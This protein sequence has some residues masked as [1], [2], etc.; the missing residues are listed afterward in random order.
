MDL[1]TT[2]T[3]I[4]WLN[5]QVTNKFPISPTTFLDAAVKLNLLLAD[6]QAHLF[7]LEQK[8]AQLR[9]DFLNEDDK[10]NVSKAKLL[11]EASEEFKDSKNQ[12]AKI[13]RIIEFIRLAKVQ[14]KLTMEEMRGGGLYA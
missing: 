1:V 13:D 3:I 12:K 7:E 10:R 5:E 14:S 11:V 9:I 8:V 2:D 4:T 6:E